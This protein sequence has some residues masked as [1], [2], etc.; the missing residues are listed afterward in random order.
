LT[1]KSVR[2]SS[3]LYDPLPT[4]Y[5]NIAK[6]D[7]YVIQEV[8]VQQKDCLCSN[9]VEHITDDTT[10]IERGFTCIPRNDFFPHLLC[11]KL[12]GTNSDMYALTVQRKDD[13]ATITHSLPSHVRPDIV[14][15]VTERS[16]VEMQ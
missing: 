7:W 6:E 15:I 14:L 3:G 10:N 12:V 5:S 9:N 11:A 1:K 2:F 16:F 13:T 4:Y 8:N